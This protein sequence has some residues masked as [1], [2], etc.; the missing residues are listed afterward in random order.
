[1]G[2][3]SM[4]ALNTLYA[5]FRRPPAITWASN[6]KWTVPRRQIYQSES[7]LERDVEYAWCRKIH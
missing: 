5:S 7:P 6:S 3:N 2:A 4:T 1:M